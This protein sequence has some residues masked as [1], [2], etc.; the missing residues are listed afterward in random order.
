MRGW[1]RG[2]RKRHSP[3]RIRGM[4][5]KKV[6]QSD[7]GNEWREDSGYQDLNCRIDRVARRGHCKGRRRGSRKKQ[8]QAQNHS[9]EG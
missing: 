1:G 5:G 8:T 3:A 9:V 7:G 4:E 2:S 6:A